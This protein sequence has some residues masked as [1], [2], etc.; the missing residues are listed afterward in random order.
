MLTSLRSLVL[1]S[2]ELRFEHFY[3]LVP[4]LFPYLTNIE[5]YTG[6]ETFHDYCKEL[7]VDDILKFIN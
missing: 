2:Y 7:L 5:I 3:V 6:D 4:Q 1:H